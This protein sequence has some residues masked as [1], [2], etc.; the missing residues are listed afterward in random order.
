MIPRE[1]A[2]ETL[3]ALFYKLIENF[4][5]C[6]QKSSVRVI[7]PAKTRT[8]LKASTAFFAAASLVVSTRAKVLCV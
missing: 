2:A 6:D 1:H 7:H 8:Q 5:P 3:T 4:L